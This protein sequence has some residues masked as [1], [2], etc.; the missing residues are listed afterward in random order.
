VIVTDVYASREQ[1][2]PGVTGELVA[3]AA[4]AQG[5]GR[6]EYCRDWQAA[7]ALL[8]DLTPGDVVLTLGAGDVYR[9]AEQLVAESG[10]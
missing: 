5:H 4:R 6:V 1:P 3:R 2:I 10:R 8:G 7:A 9:L